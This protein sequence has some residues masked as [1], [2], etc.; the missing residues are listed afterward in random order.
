M[1]EDAHLE[2]NQKTHAFVSSLETSAECLTAPMESKLS[3]HSL[4]LKAFTSQLQLN[5][6]ELWLSIL[7]PTLYLNKFSAFFRKTT[8]NW[9]DK[10]NLGC[11]FLLTTLEII[12]CTSLFLIMEIKQ[13]YLL[14]CFFKDSKFDCDGWVKW[15]FFGGPPKDAYLISYWFFLKLLHFSF[16]PSCHERLNVPEGPRCQ[17]LLCLSQLLAWLQHSYNTDASKQL[18]FAKSRIEFARIHVELKGSYLNTLNVMH[19]CKLS[20]TGGTLVDE[21]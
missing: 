7:D 10:V 17:I 13:F 20:N 16:F 3:V 15:C 21:Q 2:D 6:E 19:W 18:R 9:L 14:A 4:H 1:E 8:E 11:F 5:V 12:T